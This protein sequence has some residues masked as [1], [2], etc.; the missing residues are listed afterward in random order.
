MMSTSCT[1]DD[2][3]YTHTHM[4]MQHYLC[5]ALGPHPQTLQFHVCIYI[6]THYLSKYIHI[7]QLGGEV[8]LI[9][10]FV[11]ASSMYTIN[12]ISAGASHYEYVYMV[13]GILDTLTEKQLFLNVLFFGIYI[14][15]GVCVCYVFQL[16]H[17]DT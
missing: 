4:Y 9:A 16:Q 13:Y 5:I 10:H 1:N 17:D 15:M 6:Y 7:F 14:D 11:L 2:D 3:G 8:Q 12:N